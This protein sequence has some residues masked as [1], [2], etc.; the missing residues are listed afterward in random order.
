MF[1]EKIWF[2]FR[3]IIFLFIITIFSTRKKRIFEN[4]LDYPIFQINEYKKA[5]DLLNKKNTFDIFRRN[6]NVENIFI[7]ISIFPFLKREIIL[8]KK[9]KIYNILKQI[10]IQNGKGIIEIKK[11]Q[12]LF[13]YNKFNY[14][15]NFK[16]ENIPHKNKTNFIRH[17]LYHY[18]PVECLDIFE[19]SLNLNIRYYIDH[20][21]VKMTNEIIHNLMSKLLYIIFYS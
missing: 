12:A 9:N 14:L 21:R 7:L 4:V 11:N 19:Y 6:N 5:F 3:F 18:Y 1:N 10:F 15:I 8:T 16:W 13:L 2:K 17:I 20:N